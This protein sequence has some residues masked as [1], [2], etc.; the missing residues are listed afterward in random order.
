MLSVRILPRRRC[1]ADPDV[2][3]RIRAARELAKDGNAAA[4]DALE[5]AF[6][7]EPFWGVLAETAR[8]LGATRAPWASSIF[9]GAL[10][11]PHPKVVRAAAEALGN[12]RDPDVAAALIEAAQGHASYFVR[13]CALTALGKTRDSRAFDVLVA[14]S[15]ERT[16][17]G[18]V[19]S[20]AIAGL[21]ELADA[22]AMPFVLDA[23]G[24]ELSEGVRRAAV[25]AL[26][27]IAELVENERA[28]AIDALE[29]RLD[30]ETYFVAIAAILAAESVGDVRFL[31]ALERIGEQAFDGRMRRDA[32]EAAI[33]IRRESK[34]PTQVKILRDDI[35]ELREQQRKLREKIET[36]ART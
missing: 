9:I 25:T 29:R 11:H 27:R 13:A 19:E 7:R 21:A 32:M 16:W 10:S 31:P 30:D 15:E 26:G 22:R 12:F 2:V 36:I 5:T 23:S 17:N 33:R 28:R 34:V 35:D 4:R 3:A 8:A 20:G 1:A 6:D 18:T 14:A 24:A